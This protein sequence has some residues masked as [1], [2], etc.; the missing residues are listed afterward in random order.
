MTTQPIEP[1]PSRHFPSFV[2]R[3]SSFVLAL[4][5]TAP[6]A[7][8]QGNASH[9]LDFDGTNDSV[10]VTLVSPPASNYTLSAWVNLRAG[11]TWGGTRMAVL[12][13]TTCGGSV[14]LLIH[15]GTASASDPQYLELGRCGAFNGTV[16]TNPVPL[17]TWTHV[18][19]TVSAT[20]TVSYFINGLAAGTWTDT[21]KD[22]SLGAAFNLGDNSGSRRFDGQLDEVQI[23]SRVLSQAEIQDYLRRSLAGDEPGLHAYYRFD[24]GAGANAVDSAP[25]GGLAH[26]ALSNGPLW[27]TSPVPPAAVVHAG[28]HTDL[29]PGWRS[30]Y[31]VKPL[32]LDGDNI[33]G[34]D[35][36]HL[37]NLPP[38]LPA[39]LASAVI[40]SGTFPG[41]DDYSYLDDPNSLGSQFLTGTMNPNPGPGGSA[42]LFGFT[43]NAGAA[44]RTIRVGLLVDNLDGAAWNAASLT[45][46]QANGP[47]A[48]NGPVATVA[49]AFN[50]R[51]PDWVFFDITG[52]Q[53]GQTFIVRGAGGANGTA[54]LGGVA[55]DSAGPTGGLIRVSSQGIAEPYPSRLTVAGLPPAPF[56]MMLTLSNVTC[57]WQGMSVLL[58]GPGGQKVR[59]ISYAFGTFDS[60]NGPTVLTFDDIAPDPL[61]VLAEGAIPSGTYRPD[62]DQSWPEPPA[63]APSGP[64][65]GTLASAV[66]GQVA[67]VWSLYVAGTSVRI[68]SWSLAL[69][70][71][72]APVV[73]TLQ[74]STNVAFYRAT[75]RGT[76]SPAGLPTV[77]WFEWG[78]TT[79]FGFTTP[80]Q[81]LGYGASALPIDTLI[82]NLAGA[83][84]YFR[85]AASNSLGVSYGTPLSFSLPLFSSQPLYGAE[86]VVRSALAWGDYDNDGRLDLLVAGDSANYQNPS[87]VPELWQNTGNS[88]VKSS[89]SALPAVTGTAVAWGDYDNDGRLD[90]LLTGSSYTGQVAQVWRNTEQP[91]GTEFEQPDL[92]GLPG[93]HRGAVA[94]GDYD[95]DGRLDFLLAG[96]RSSGPLAQL[97][98]NTGDGFTNLT[99]S[100]A[101]GLPEVHDGAVAWGDYD[102]DGWL[103]FLLTGRSNSVRVAQVW[104]NTGRGFTNATA[105]VAPG[106]PGVADSSVAWGDFDNDSRLDFVLTG[107]T[108]SSSGVSQLWRNT[109]SGFSNVTANLAPGLPG[110]SHGTVAW[111]DVDNDG[112]LDLLLSGQGTNI[113][114]VVQL[115]QNTGSNFIN[116]TATLLPGLPEV[117]SSSVAWG[118]VDNDGRLDF[119]LTGQGTNHFGNEAIAQVWR[120]RLP[121]TNTP[122]NAPAG[123]SVAAGSGAVTFSWA[124]ASDTQTPASGLAYHLRIGTTPGGSDLLTPMAATNGQA[125]LPR[126]GALQPAR[127]RTITGLP[128][129][130]TLYWSVQAAD[131]AFAGSPFAV[132]QSF[133]LA[134]A[135][136]PTNGVV[137]PGD[138]N[139]DGI[140]DATELATVLASVQ[141]GLATLNAAGYYTPAQVQALNVG[142]PLLS[143]T[144]PG[145]FK[146]TLGLQKATQLT[147]FVAFP[148]LAPQTLINAQG[149]LEFLFTSEDGAAFFRVEAR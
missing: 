22:F 16:S 6:L 35:G 90:F 114:D 32:N 73:E 50:N 65:A 46:V 123:L 11:G 106:L 121:V 124:A 89:F 148:F 109:G 21:S 54:T 128:T 45:L 133:T 144:A 102:N 119:V 3:P 51:T 93:N 110:V 79:N 5:L 27:V 141:G 84:Y 25:A 149:Q 92:R 2:L 60:A 81:A 44:G 86:G 23:W 107:A 20:K 17:N 135:L 12:S 28:N 1:L 34:T 132:G 120:N 99:A 8:A 71:L 72:G 143:Q 7:R 145:Q 49:P 100:L 39:Y 14:E 67:G 70:P 125:R 142:T 130:R 91:W 29:G 95:N 75:L 18:A 112:R 33:L 83:T 105:S 129:G 80:A 146:L 53:A 42:D 62:S 87:A 77:A 127:S 19:V 43:L 30:Y 113:N 41:N 37:V 131:T 26:G 134:L 40:L 136:T 57:P 101:P 48:S 118:D 15:S 137:T 96:H 98:R 97:W 52:G 104:R 126:G 47:P 58:V 24:A 55:F 68:D 61:P 66:T 116:A 138:T 122:P 9:A 13:S 56:K 108:N 117:R 59:P 63:P 78:T 140:V 139:G 115:W 94:W 31:P 147:N 76:V 74:A 38:V 10:S 69:V 64:Y 85:A 88:L 36:Y 4:L 111:G 82:T 103:G